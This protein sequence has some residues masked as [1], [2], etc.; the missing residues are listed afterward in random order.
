MRRPQPCR[1]EGGR[2]GPAT[3]GG[4]QRQG[5]GG[6]SSVEPAGRTIDAAAGIGGVLA[7]VVIAAAVVVG[8]GDALAVVVADAIRVT[9]AAAADAEG[10]AGSVD[11]RRGACRCRCGR[12]RRLRSTSSPSLTAAD[13]CRQKSNSPAGRNEKSVGVYVGHMAVDRGGTYLGEDCLGVLGR[14]TGPQGGYVDDMMDM[15]RGDRLASRMCL[16]LVNDK[17]LQST[18]FLC[19]GL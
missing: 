17:G 19:F 11:A 5:G 3:A 18:I 16:S 14:S 13:S 9:A 10:V 6:G 15:P 7:D 2:G 4:R 1:A 12:R 8:V